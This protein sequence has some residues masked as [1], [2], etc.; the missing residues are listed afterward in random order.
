MTKP[1]KKRVQAVQA[2]SMQAEGGRAPFVPPITISDRQLLDGGRDDAF[3]EVLYLMVSSLGRLQDCREAFAR[4]IR[5]S[6]P[7]FAVLMGTAYKQGSAGIS[8]R[9]L[10]AYVQLAATHVTTEVGRLHQLGYLEKHPSPDDRRSVLVKMTSLGEQTVKTVA[11]FVRAV[12]DQLFAEVTRSE[13]DLLHHFFRRF[14]VNSDNALVEIRET[15]SKV[16]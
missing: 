2:P 10:A 1:S 12:N 6:S 15:E 4:A 3:R 9:D 8:I 5:L 11:P 7:Q 13:L 14:C 16:G